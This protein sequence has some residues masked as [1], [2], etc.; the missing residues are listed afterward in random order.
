M[1]EHEITAAG[2]RYKCSCGELD[3]LNRWVAD[4]HI[5]EVTDVDSGALD[6]PDWLLN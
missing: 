2:G 3:T 6:A 1:T 4:A 5:D